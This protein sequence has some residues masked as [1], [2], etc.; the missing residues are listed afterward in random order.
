MARYSRIRQYRSHGITVEFSH[1]RGNHGGITAVLPH[2][3]CRV[4]H[5]LLLMHDMGIARQDTHK[6]RLE[7]KF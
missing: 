5:S 4:I 1:S 2:S 6:R 7:C 3:H